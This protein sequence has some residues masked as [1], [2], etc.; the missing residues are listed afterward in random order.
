MTVSNTGQDYLYHMDNMSGCY[1]HLSEYSDQLRIMIMDWLMKKKIDIDIILHA[2]I[3][4]SFHD[5]MDATH[6]NH[7]TNN[8]K[9]NYGRKSQSESSNSDSDDFEDIHKKGSSKVTSAM[10]S[11]TSTQFS[12]PESDTDYVFNKG[13]IRQLLPETYDYRFSQI[14]YGKSESFTFSCEFKINM[15][16]DKK[17]ENGLM[18]TI[19][20][21][22]T[23]W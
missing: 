11:P 15:K 6:I 12:D 23:Q 9:E 16:S 3:H 19:K 10:N 2:D 1:I 13:T 17:L 18:N 5:C 7:D 4:S 8:L 14:Q 21:Q 20:K 22:K